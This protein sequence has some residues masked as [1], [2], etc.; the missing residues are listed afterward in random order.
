MLVKY[1]YQTPEDSEYKDNFYGRVYSVLTIDFTPD[2]IYPRYAV[3]DKDFNSVIMIQAERCEILRPDLP[4]D[5]E[6]EF[7]KPGYYS[8][9]PKEFSRDFWNK[10]YDNDRNAQTTMENVIEKVEA[11]DQRTNA[12]L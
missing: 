8:V 1:V 4:V 2:E 11:F 12:C 7:F 6:F 10:Y 3:K 9:Q 5:W